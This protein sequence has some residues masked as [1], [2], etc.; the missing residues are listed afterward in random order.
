MKEYRGADYFLERFSGNCLI[1]LVVSHDDKELLRRRNDGS[2][3]I[4]INQGS[5]SVTGVDFHPV[6]CLEI[7]KNLFPD[8]AVRGRIDQ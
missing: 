5:F 1:G 7:G 4:G 8:A 3:I 2:G 6:D